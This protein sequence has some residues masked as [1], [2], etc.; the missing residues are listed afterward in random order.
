MIVSDIKVGICG[1][2]GRMG[3]TL[4]KE[5]TLDETLQL[6]AALEDSKHID[7]GKDSGI[8]AGIEESGGDN[9]SRTFVITEEF[10]QGTES[11]TWTIQSAYV[12]DQLGNHKYQD[13]ALLLLLPLPGKPFLQQCLYN[14]YPVQVR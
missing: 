12:R 10:A 1:A 5:V 8:I 7:I 14:Y 13:G 6:T 9:K 3:R 11:G 2:A 4:V